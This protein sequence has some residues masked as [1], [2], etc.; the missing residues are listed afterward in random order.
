MIGT[1][2]VEVRLALPVKPTWDR[3][4]EKHPR[5]ASH[6]KRLL[7]TIRNEQ[8]AMTTAKESKSNDVAACTLIVEVVG[9]NGLQLGEDDKRAT[10]PSPYVHYHMV[11]HGDTMTNV[12]S[13][14]YVSILILEREHFSL[15]LSLSLHHTNHTLNISTLIS[16]TGTAQNFNTLVDT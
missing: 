5:Q 8:V 6:A 11:G 4:K 7:K 1:V 3:F 15:S 16:L 12:V 9:C 2:D 13:G 10:L 14:S